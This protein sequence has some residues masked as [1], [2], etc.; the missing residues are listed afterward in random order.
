MT[1]CERSGRLPCSTVRAWFGRVR[2][3][4]GGPVD[5]VFDVVGKAPVEDLISLAPEASQVVT[6]ANFA[7]GQAGARVAGGPPPNRMD[8][9]CPSPGPIASLAVPTAHSHVRRHAVC[10][11]AGV[12]R[13]CASRSATVIPAPTSI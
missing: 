9:S 13:T 10:S 5:A 6:I 7:A 11:R 3:A 1:T 4:V 12:G 8:S 2:A